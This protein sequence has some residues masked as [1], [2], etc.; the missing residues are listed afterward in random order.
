VEGCG[1]VAV[2]ASIVWLDRELNVHM[3]R[4]Q[5]WYDRQHQI[6]KDNIHFVHSIYTIQELASYIFIHGYPGQL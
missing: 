5:L 4:V 6:Y 3:R 2:V 1:G